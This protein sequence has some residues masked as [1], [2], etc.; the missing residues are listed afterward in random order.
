[1]GGSRQVWVGLSGWSVFARR[2]VGLAGALAVLAALAV[3]QPFVAPASAVGPPTLTVTPA[4]N[5]ADMQLVTATLAGIPS[6]SYVVVVECGPGAGYDACDGS[7]AV[8]PTLDA[9]GMATA[10]VQVAAI[11][12]P[13]AGGSIDCRAADP[14]H[15]CVVRARAY[16]QSNALDFSVPVTFDP[17][18]ALAPPP[19]FSIDPAT[20]LSDGQTV[21]IHGAGF[22]PGRLVFVRLCRAATTSCEVA[23]GPTAPIGTATAAGVVTATTVLRSVITVDPY[24]RIDCRVAG[25]CEIRVYTPRSGTASIVAPVTFDPGTGAPTWPTLKLL[26]ATGLV[27]RQK[28]LAAGSGYPANSYV[29][30]LEC[31]ATCRSIGTA[32]TKADGTFATASVVYA[33]VAD[34]TPGGR[35]DCRPVAGTCRL[36]ATAYTGTGQDVGLAGLAFDPTAPLAPPPTAVATPSTDLVDAQ[37]ITVSGTGFIPAGPNAGVNVAQCATGVGYA[38]QYG[39][40]AGV[41]VDATG[42]L[43]GDV[44]VSTILPGSGADLD[45]RVVA[46]ELQVSQYQGTGEV[47]HLPLSF[48]P[49]A[50][51]APAASFT[52]TPSTGLADGQAVHIH[53][54][55]LRRSSY[56]SVQE[57]RAGSYTQ[58]TPTDCRSLSAYLQ[59]DDQ[60]EADVSLVVDAALSLTVPAP[61]GFTALDP[62]GSVAPSTVSVGGTVPVTVPPVVTES[63]DCRVEAAG[64]VLVMA[65]G[66]NG[67]SGAQLT[68]QPISFG[69]AAAGT[70]YVDRVFA[71]VDVTRDVVYGSAVFE[72]GVRRDLHLDMYEPHGDTATQRPVII[73]MHGGF[74]AFGDQ[75]EG[76]TVGDE[77]ARR[78]YVVISVEYRLYNEGGIDAA[79]RYQKAIP[80]AQHDSQAAIRYMRRHAAELRVGP[81]AFGAIGYSAGAVTALNLANHADDPGD[82]GNPGFPS[83][84]LGAVSLSGSHGSVTPHAPP[85][86]MFH[87]VVDHTVAYQFAVAG[88][89]RAKA[90]GDECTLVSY[91]NTDH[92]IYSQY[93]DWM[94]QTIAF[95]NRTVVPGLASADPGTTTTTTSTT[96]PGSPST[97]TTTGPSAADPI[98]FSTVAAAAAVPAT[99][100]FTG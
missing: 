62:A 67:S 81:R 74:F 25:N 22:T 38:C 61:G 55:H 68:S 98:V 4:L 20:G 21:T 71:S 6:A 1:M 45:C 78:G 14:A 93:G 54:S 12:H 2:V 46:C 23:S 15:P 94:P 37:M 13:D 44:Q 27:D 75:G 32:Q 30:I 3:V 49:A 9:T 63:Y 36:A 24:E 77:L 31:A 47:L 80:A 64:C 57:C 43:H 35:T 66:G 89:E 58:L 16:A 60:G 26:P 79:S 18:G 91:P 59:P 39:G 82:S 92:D 99:P 40:G 52:V 83:D 48:D 10:T 28:V 5:L 85:V 84:V 72:D 97:T 7:T 42:A 69:P 90:I 96:V 29:S 65:V 73:Y 100:S 88:C 53:A 33:S 50:P 56:A 70:R 86:L 41:T 19:T 95:F 51:L 87:G 17:A 76:A 11:L 8:Y 34:G